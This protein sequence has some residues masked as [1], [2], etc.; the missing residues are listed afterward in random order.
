MQAADEVDRDTGPRP[1]GWTLAAELACAAPV[2]D[3]GFGAAV[4]ALLPA[5]TWATH[6]AGAI[7]DSVFMAVLHAQHRRGSGAICLQC[8]RRATGALP[9]E[10]PC[11]ALA[12]PCGWSF[13]LVERSAPPT[14]ILAAATAVIQI[15]LFHE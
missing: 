7:A 3:E 2:D 14:A 9:P 15:Y 1:A 4:A 13:F 10:L 5:G 11:A 12:S 6:L 8:Y